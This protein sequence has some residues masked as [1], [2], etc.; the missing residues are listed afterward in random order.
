MLTSTIPKKKKKQEANGSPEVQMCW[1]SH[2]EKAKMRDPTIGLSPSSPSIS[3]SSSASTLVMLVFRVKVIHVALA[4]RDFREHQFVQ[5]LTR[6]PMRVS[7]T[8]ADQYPLEGGE[9]GQEGTAT[10]SRPKDS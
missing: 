3:P 1:D 8:L 7:L 4:T 6:E 5:S 9:G 2:H 10:S